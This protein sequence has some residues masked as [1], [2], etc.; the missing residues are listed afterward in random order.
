LAEL[1]RIF[2]NSPL[3]TT[4]AANVMIF[5]PAAALR[6]LPP[7]QRRE[8]ERGL[9]FSPPRTRLVELEGILQ[10]VPELSTTTARAENE[11]D[12]LKPLR[13]PV[14]EQRLRHVRHGDSRLWRVLPGAPVAWVR[15]KWVAYPSQ[16]D[17]FQWCRDEGAFADETLAALRS[18]F[19]APPGSAVQGF[20]SLPFPTGAGTS[21]VGVLNVHSDQPG[22][23][24]G[25]DPVRHLFPLLNPILQIVNDLVDLLVEAENGAKSENAGGTQ[26]A[27]ETDEPPT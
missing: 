14:P 10:L 19:D 7:E 13:L 17:L 6:K 1:I 22:L 3:Q 4:Y 23:F 16:A 5:R 8:W 26:D 15:K 18:Y 9:A 11:P 25:R 21:P 24:A 20:A 2:E 12:E 27:G